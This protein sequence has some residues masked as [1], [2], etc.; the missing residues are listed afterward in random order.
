LSVVLT[1]ARV[2]SMSPLDPSLVVAGLE[3]LE[4]L[5]SSISSDSSSNIGSSSKSVISW[6]SKI[7][8]GGESTWVLPDMTLALRKTQ[9]VSILKDC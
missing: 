3:T 4:E 6:S 7:R 1:C 5:D 2:E 8:G 9:M